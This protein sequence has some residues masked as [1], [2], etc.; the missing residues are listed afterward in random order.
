LIT[1]QIEEDKA[2][3]SRRVEIVTPLLRVSSGPTRAE[4]NAGSVH[5]MLSLSTHG[6]IWV[7]GANTRI[8]VYKLGTQEEKPL[9][10]IARLTAGTK[11]RVYALCLVGT[12][13][14]WSGGEDGTIYSWPVG[15]V[16]DVRLLFFFSQSWL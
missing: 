6:Q 4:S 16:S 7:G 14:I 13:E 1:E 2:M 11:G 9:E 8:D 15:R 10:R 3:L 5:T 12:D